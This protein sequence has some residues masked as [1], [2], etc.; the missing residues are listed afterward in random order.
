[1]KPM[2]FKRSKFKLAKFLDAL[3]RF[4]VQHLGNGDPLPAVSGDTVY[5]DSADLVEALSTDLGE[6][7]GNIPDDSLARLKQGLALYGMFAASNGFDAYDCVDGQ[8]VEV[9]NFDDEDEDD[10]PTTPRRRRTRRFL[11]MVANTPCDD[12]TSFGFLVSVSGD[13]VEVEPRAM[14]DV[15]GDCELEMM[16]EPN[17]LSDSMRKWVR[18]FLFPKRGGK[19]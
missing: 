7:S 1:M 17:L 4:S 19:A 14:R 8:E 10:E 3:H 13:K 18:S 2:I 12:C 5:H 9:P 16:L 11:E 15:D 6:E